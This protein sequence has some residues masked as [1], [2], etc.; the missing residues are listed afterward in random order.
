MSAGSAPGHQ[1][2]PAHEEY[3]TEHLPSVELEATGRLVKEQAGD[4]LGA[5]DGGVLQVLV[6]L[7]LIQSVLAVGDAN[8]ITLIPARMSRSSSDR[9]VS[10]EMSSLMSMG[11]SSFDH[12]TRLY[13]PT[14]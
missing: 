14:P 8:T 13:S 1:H 7:W 12:R 10:T 11:W 9:G 5:D 6:R 2:R 4:E 3:R